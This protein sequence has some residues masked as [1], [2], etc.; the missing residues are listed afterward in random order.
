MV[1]TTAW[2]S[3]QLGGT[4]VPAGGADGFADASLEGGV[5]VPDSLGFTTNT[6]AATSSATASTA[7]AIGI[8][9]DARTRCLASLR[10]FPKPGL[11]GMPKK[12][13]RHGSFDG[14]ARSQYANICA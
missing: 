14:H 6:T 11:D 2:A 8:H 12:V 7:N 1:L 10:I 13:P 3:L 5:V 9:R 4:G